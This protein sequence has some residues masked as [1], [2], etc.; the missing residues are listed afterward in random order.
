MIEIDL[1]LLNTQ[2]KEGI[3]LGGKVLAVRQDPGITDLHSSQTN[4]VAVIPPSPCISSFGS[5]VHSLGSQP[6]GT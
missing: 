5:Y 6:H 4:M 3:V 2:G 1:G